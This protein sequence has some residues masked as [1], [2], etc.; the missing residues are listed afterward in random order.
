[1]QTNPVGIPESYVLKNS[2]DEVIETWKRNN[3]SP[4]WWRK[5]KGHWIKAISFL[6]AAGDYFI[7]HIDNLLENG[8]D[9]KATVLEALGKVYDAI[10]PPYLPFFLRPFNNKIKKFALE[11]IASIMIDFFVGKYRAGNWEVESEMEPSP[12]EVDG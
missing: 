12:E 3:P 4:S 2:I 5:I 7:R 10:V 9:K 11:V 8:P 1:M 6:V